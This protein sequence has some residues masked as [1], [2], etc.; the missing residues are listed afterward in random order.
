MALCDIPLDERKSRSKAGFFTDFSMKIAAGLTAIAIGVV[1]VKSYY[2]DPY[3]NHTVCEYQTESGD[4]LTNILRSEGLSGSELDEA[5]GNVCEENYDRTMPDDPLK[6]VFPR[7]IGNSQ[8][9]IMMD[10]AKIAVPDYDGDGFINGQEC[11]DTQ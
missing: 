2:S 5:V 9:D 1:A 10:R 7:Y 3:N 8:C 6:P 4:S 11:K